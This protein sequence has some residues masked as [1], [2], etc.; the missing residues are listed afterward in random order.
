MKIL[1][2][3]FLFAP[4]VFL[5]RTGSNFTGHSIND[6]EKQN[7]HFFWRYLAIVYQMKGGH[8]Y[9]IV[10]WSWSYH[11][12]DAGEIGKIQQY[13]SSRNKV[14]VTWAVGKY[15]VIDQYLVSTV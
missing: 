9:N 3:P 13:H 6:G 4:N 11:D 15:C 1:V 14:M 5:A 12:D 7:F 8:Y 10:S 2:V